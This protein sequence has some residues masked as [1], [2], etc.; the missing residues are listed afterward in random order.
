MPRRTSE[1]AT[2]ATP[3]GALSNSAPFGT[4][5]HDEAMCSTAPFTQ[6]AT[7]AFAGT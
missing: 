2:I 1:P 3:S 7:P 6:E 4:I 5:S